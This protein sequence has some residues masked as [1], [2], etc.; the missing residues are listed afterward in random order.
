MLNFR[1]YKKNAL[2][3]EAF[4]FIL[5]TCVGNLATRKLACSQNATRKLACSQNVTAHSLSGPSLC[6]RASKIYAIYGSAKAVTQ[7]KMSIAGSEG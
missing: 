7:C 3:L 2:Y 5:D 6:S 4:S 1:H